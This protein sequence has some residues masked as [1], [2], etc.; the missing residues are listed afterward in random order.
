MTETITVTYCDRCREEIP[1]AF[2]FYYNT[3]PKTTIKVQR[4]EWEY[5]DL[6]DKCRESFKAWWENGRQAESEDKG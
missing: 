1:K 2:T 4:E 6:C 3:Q 5:A